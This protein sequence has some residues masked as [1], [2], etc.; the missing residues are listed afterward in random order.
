MGGV[1]RRQPGREVLKVRGEESVSIW[2]KGVNRE[3]KR[4]GVDDIEGEQGIG[5]REKTGN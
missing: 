5:E 2:R 1:G 4:R 3:G